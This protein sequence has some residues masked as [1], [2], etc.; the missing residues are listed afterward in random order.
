[1]NVDFGENCFGFRPWTPVIG[2]IFARTFSL[3]CETTRIDDAHPWLAPA[4]VIGAAFDG[5][6]GYFVRGADVAGFFEAHA[7]VPVA[8]HNAAFDLAVIDKLAPQI[9][10]YKRVEKHRV[11]D[12]QLLHRLCVLGTSGL[13]AGGKG[14]SDLEHCAD[15]YL[16]VKLPKDVTDSRGNVVR[17]SY[18]QW[19]TAP[20]QEIEPIYLEYLAKDAIA[21]RLVY[22]A[23]RKRLKLLLARSHRVWGF[24]SPEWLDEQVRTWGPQTHHIQL[25]ASIV[26]KEITA[27]GLHLDLNRKSE[28]AEGLEAELAQ[29]RKSLR[30]FGHLPDGKGAN[31]SLQAVLRRAENKCRGVRFPRTETGLYA[32]SHEGLQDLVDTVPF[33]KVLLEYR[34][35]DKLLG[36]F[37][38]KM[39]QRVLH[40]SFNVLVR[41]GRTSSFGE[42]NAQ[43]LPKDERVRSC[44]VPSSGN[45]FIDSDYKTIEL[46]TLAQACNAQFGLKSR[47]AAAINAGKD[48]HTLVAARV[49]NKTEAEVTKEERAKAKPINFGKPGGMG[50]S[51]LKQYAKV[52]YGI[53]YSEAE[54]KAFSDGWFDLFPEMRKFL[55]DDMDIT[56]E[57]AKLLDLTPVSHF[58]HTG[59]ARFASHPENEGR[60]HRPNSVL[61]GMCLKALKTDS[62]RTGAGKPYSAADLD[63]FWSQLE[64]KVSSFSLSFQDEIVRRQPS[65]RLQRE[66]MSR[67]GRAGCFTLSGRLRAK[68]TYSARHNTI[69]Q[70]LAADG[71]KL[72]LWLLWRAGYRIVNFIHDQVLIEVPLGSDLKH[73]AE[74]IRGLMV[75]GM[76]LVVPD[77]EVDVSFAAA[78]RW[79]KDA[80]AAYDKTGKRL[81][82]YKPKS[83]RREKLTLV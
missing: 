80:E 18:G 60:E 23:L 74:R 54:V 58:E 25:Q 75:Q 61:G 4:Y 29:L 17:L 51:T 73:E 78:D 77:V 7:N 65:I 43:N 49:K 48:V 72:A 24:V 71:A 64:L 34:E 32:T 8:F 59:D 16:K 37:L 70:G 28:L 21:T 39:G 42:I 38:A 36:S 20:P 5:K 55:Q 10:I 9:D 68:A 62:P 22:R 3:D 6:Q 56:L 46:A 67:V 2:R 79:Y 52:S 14:E 40:P 82:L 81:L 15:L 1:M 11:W 19:L 12:T 63:Y 27:N 30:K 76:K 45:V 35:T 26:L 66:V 50:D 53:R 33:V 69:F 41:S 57:L 47:M 44:F 31:K 83:A 13:T